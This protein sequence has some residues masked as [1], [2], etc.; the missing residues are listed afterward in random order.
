[1]ICGYNGYAFLAF[2]MIQLERRPLSRRLIIHLWPLLTGQY[3]QKTNQLI[4]SNQFA[5]SMPI[6]S[7]CLLAAIQWCTPPYHKTGPYHMV[8]DQSLSGQA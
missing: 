7:P 8:L 4:K 2:N 6:P 5:Q 3:H 1:M